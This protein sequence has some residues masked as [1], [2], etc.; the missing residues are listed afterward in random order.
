MKGL[1]TVLFLSG[2]LLASLAES[3]GPAWLLA[4]AGS[5][6]S[7]VAL[8]VICVR[9]ETAVAAAQRSR[10]ETLEASALRPSPVPPEA[11]N[12]RV[13]ASVEGMSILTPSA[14]LSR[15]PRGGTDT[16]PRATIPG[17]RSTAAPLP[18]SGHRQGC[19][20]P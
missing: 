10:L 6:V 1:R 5:L 2:I 11:A 20:V 18:A 9:E 15:G 16:A 12:G 3:S 4:A 14:S 19:S 17:R 13:I 8:L 7:F